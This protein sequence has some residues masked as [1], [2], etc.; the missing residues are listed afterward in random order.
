MTRNGRT[1]FAKCSTKPDFMLNRS[2][3]LRHPIYAVSEER[4]QQ[5]RCQSPSA[6]A[7]PCHDLLPLLTLLRHP[8]LKLALTLILRRVGCEGNT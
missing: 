7:W 8:Q 6:F 3:D 5:R 4:P 1:Q 2:L